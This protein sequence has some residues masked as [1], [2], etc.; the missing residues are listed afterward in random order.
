MCSHLIW[1]T[2]SSQGLLDE[3]KEGTVFSNVALGQL[4]MLQGNSLT[5]VTH[6]SG[7]GW[8]NQVTKQ[9]KNKTKIKSG[10]GV[11]WEE[12]EVLMGAGGGRIE[13]MKR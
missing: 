8:L 11:W 9:N 6:M 10:I 1:K 2:K 4:F 5:P 12:G 3:R 13:R 7:P